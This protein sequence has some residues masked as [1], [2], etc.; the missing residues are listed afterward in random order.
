M[1]KSRRGFLALLGM[2]PIAGVAAAKTE[3]TEYAE[4]RPIRGE[5]RSF[6]DHYETHKHVHTDNYGQR[7]YA[8][9]AVPIAV[10]ALK[11]FDGKQWVLL[12]SPKGQE[13][14]RTLGSPS[15]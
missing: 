2:A 9:N 7:I 13:I 5:V 4:V 14:V 8:D 10:M 11:V 3:P 15:H 1:A 12:D 6:F